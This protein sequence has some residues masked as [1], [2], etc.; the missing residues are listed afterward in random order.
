MREIT[1]WGDLVRNDFALRNS[2]RSS[3]GSQASDYNV[4][5]NTVRVCHYAYILTDWRSNSSTKCL[6]LDTPAGDSELTCRE[7]KDSK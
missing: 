6:Q 4:H 3:F 2:A 5:F 7:S 1:Q